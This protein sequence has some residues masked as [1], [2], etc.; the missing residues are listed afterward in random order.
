MRPS[1][2]KAKDGG[3]VDDGHAV[4]LTLGVYRLSLDSTSVISISAQQL[5][6]ITQASHDQSSWSVNVLFAHSRIITVSVFRYRK[7][8]I[9]CV[10]RHKQGH[11]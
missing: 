11:R 3:E 1:G 8:K 6:A 5:E 7:D 9:R 10:Q 2:W 4:L